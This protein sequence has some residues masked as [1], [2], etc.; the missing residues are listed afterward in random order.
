MRH[1]D[2]PYADYRKNILLTEIT[3]KL[4][5]SQSLL[6]QLRLTTFEKVVCL[7]PTIFSTFYIFSLSYRVPGWDLKFNFAK[8]WG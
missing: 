4:P 1:L 2:P 7:H 5:G 8:K 3:G 6:R